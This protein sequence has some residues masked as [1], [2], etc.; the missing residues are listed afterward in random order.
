LDQLETLTQINLNDLVTSFGWQ[1]QPLL[2]RV[3]RRV[4]VWPARTFAEHMV[5]FDSA[6]GE[7]GLAAASRFTQRHYVKDVRLFSDPLPAGPFLALSNHPGMTDTLSLFCALGRPDLKI[8]ALDR[9]FLKALPNL[10][11][12]L[13]YLRE[14]ATSRM[15]LVRQ[16]TLHLRA[17]GAALTFPAG[18]IEPDPDVYKGATESLQQWTDSAGVF[19]RMAPETA[20]L[21]VLVRG[22]VWK[23]AARHPLLYIK[24]TR[25]ERETLAAA[26]QLLAHVM[27]NARPVTVRVQVGKP[28][29]ARE[30]GTTEPSV[31]HEAVLAG[32]K[33]LIENP[34]QG[35]GRSVM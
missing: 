14:D 31:I 2:S 5:E 17:G 33:Q 27:W 12:Q 6:T 16:V 13:F 9:P 28:I 10:S 3:L 20:V 29:Y 26:F 7:R 4:F 22:V 8:I 23:K 19:V 21:P 35:E 25:A 24:R 32:M 34:P 18:H 15:S 11:K 1:N 30:L